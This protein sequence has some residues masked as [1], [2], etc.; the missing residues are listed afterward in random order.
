MNARTPPEL[1][2]DRGVLRFI[3]AGSVD[4]G[5]STLIGRLLFDSRGILADQLAAMARA[6]D[7]RS[8]LPAGH[9]AGA[10]AI[11]LSLLTDGLE[12]EREQGITIDVAYRYFATARRKFIIA[13]TPGHEQYTR[14]MVTAASTADAAVILVDATRVQGGHLLAQTRRHTALAQLLG[15]RQIAVAVNKMDRFDFAEPV[16]DAIVRA[17][18]ELAD[19]LGIE[20]FTA[21]PVSA[22]EGDN[23][24][25]LSARTPWYGGPSLLDWLEGVPS[26]CVAEA[27]DDAPLRL[28]VQLVLRGFDAATAAP[29]AYAGRIGSG[30]VRVGDRIVVQPS[31]AP[32]VVAAIETFDGGLD[33]AGSGQSIALR[34][35]RDIDVSR[36]DL[37]VSA[38]APVRLASSLE[39]DLSWLDDEPSQASRKYW[40]RHGTREVQ[41]IVRR[42]ERVLDLGDVRWRD[43]TAPDLTLVR[44]DI[45]QVVIET[46]QPLAFDAYGRSR[47]GGAF[48]LID[49]VT[50]RTVAAGM[51]RAQRAAAA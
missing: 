2:E 7:R 31:G 27:L 16:F 36:G 37:I 46:Q 45:A 51:L 48:V 12:A 23:V 33:E 24:V 26:M 47:V 34:L 28:P 19:R 1:L 5:K 18:R 50:N 30:S 15:V 10:S 42:V 38:A 13:D 43:A 25:T 44:N 14:N 21:I 3:T 6:T 39:A 17:Y 11:D 49:R 20:R 41:A 32:A 40:L 4:D 8:G 22:L 9:S 35:D 29:R